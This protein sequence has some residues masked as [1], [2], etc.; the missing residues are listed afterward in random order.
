MASDRSVHTVVKDFILRE[1]LPEEDP[2]ELQDATPLITTGVL[3]SIATLKLVDFLEKHY[4]IQI[5]A[6]EASVVYLNTIGDI[7]RL[8][9]SKVSPS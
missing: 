4:G 7:A 8:V 2:G 5:A 6:H 3:D 9:E 1:F